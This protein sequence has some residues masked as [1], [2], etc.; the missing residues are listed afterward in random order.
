MTSELVERISSLGKW[1]H[2]ID[3]GG[4]VFT[5]G[6]R[7]QTLTFNLFAPHLPHDMTGMRVLD[8]GANAC[9]LSVEFAKRG[10]TVVAVEHSVT[11]CRQ[12]QFVIDHFGLS[13]K[14]SIEKTDLFNVLS[15]GTFDIVAYVGLSYHIRYPQLALDMLTHSCSGT[16]LVST[17][18]I[19]GDSLTTVNRARHT[20]GRARGELYGWEPTETLFLDMIEHAGFV[21]AT[22][23]S[24]A[25]HPG[26]DAENKLGNRSYFI[27]KAG[28][29]TELP[30]I[31]AKIN[32]KPQIQYHAASAVANDTGRR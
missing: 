27:A 13:D 11:Y 20:P 26:E 15:L 9:G 5:P 7:N 12:A 14:I 8:L 16:L 19:P 32:S 6:D 18:T 25:P 31:S 2:R 17:Q 28:R 10:A 1:Y 3:M 30:F 22:L 23:L 24:T 4:G 29:K 21:N